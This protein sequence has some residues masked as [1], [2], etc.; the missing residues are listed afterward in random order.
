MPLFDIPERASKEAQTGIAKKINKNNT[1]KSA[2]SGVSNKIDMIVNLCKERLG[3]YISKYSVIYTQEELQSYIDSCIKNGIV[4][5][6]TETTGL[7]PITDDIV[8]ISLY[9]PNEKA[10]Y[11]PIN[12]R[13]Y[14]TKVK[15]DKQI[16][17]LAVKT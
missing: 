10:V 9:T 2:R 6:D 17:I 14:I 13:N 4:A 5:I 1:I 3:K 12:H 16:E 8:G 15:T 7:D 11:I